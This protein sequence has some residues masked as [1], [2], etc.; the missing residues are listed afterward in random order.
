MK[1]NKAHFKA[2]VAAAAVAALASVLAIYAE[3]A[4]D[5]RLGSSVDGH[6]VRNSVINFFGLWATLWLVGGLFALPFLFV[7]KALETNF[8]SPRLSIYGVAGALSGLAGVV[9]SLLLAGAIFGEPAPLISWTSYCPVF[10]LSG[11]LGGLVY[12]WRSG[13]S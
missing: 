9:F 10:C 7:A 4:A 13:T 12:G 2:Y 11:L 1:N 6:A 5:N 3:A 8:R